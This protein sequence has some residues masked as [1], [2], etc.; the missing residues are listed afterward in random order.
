MRGESTLFK[1]NASGG[2]LA[3]HIESIKQTNIYI[4]RFNV[5]DERQELLLSTVKSHT[6][7]WFGHVCR[8]DT[9]PKIII[10]QGTVDGRRGRRRPRNSLKDNI[11]EWTDQSMLSLLMSGEDIDLLPYIFVRSAVSVQPSHPRS[12]NVKTN[13]L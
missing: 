4:T 12:S 10:Q 2:Y 1:T 8:H 13:D 11:N 5:L 7:S 9:L 6:L 3:Y